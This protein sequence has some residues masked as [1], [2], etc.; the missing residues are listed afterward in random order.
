MIDNNSVTLP[1]ECAIRPSSECQTAIPEAMTPEFGRL[2]RDVTTLDSGVLAACSN[3]SL[4][5]SDL[6]N[7]QIEM[8]QLPSPL[9]QEIAGLE[10]SDPDEIH[11]GA[12]AQNQLGGIDNAALAIRNAVTTS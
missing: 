10:T 7:V 4:I 1:Y 11:M 5:A 2:Q 9:G 3:S 6:R 12:E 8:N